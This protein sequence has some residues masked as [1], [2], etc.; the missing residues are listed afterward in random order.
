MMSIQALV[1]PQG[2][3][4]SVGWV[5]I[6]T[7][8]H[9]FDVWGFLSNSLCKYILVGV[10]LL[11]QVN[12]RSIFFAC[13]FTAREE[14]L[15][16]WSLI[17]LE[18]LAMHPSGATT[19]SSR[20][21]RQAPNSRD[22]SSRHCSSV[23]ASHTKRSR[24]TGCVPSQRSPVWFE[25]KS[26]QSCICHF[27]WQ[28]HCWFFFRQTY[29]RLFAGNSHQFNLRICTMWNFFFAC[30]CPSVECKANGVLEKPRNLCAA[31]CEP[32][33]SE[34][35][36]VSCHVHYSVAFRDCCV[37]G[38]VQAQVN[39]GTQLDDFECKVRG[40]LR[41]STAAAHCISGSALERLTLGRYDKD[42]DV[43]I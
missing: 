3:L 30:K 16:S 26:D 19:V 20:R 38:Q 9:G 31:E 1:T 7:A 2:C 10:A 8:F 12:V 17:L 11:S 14:N 35:W 33:W 32:G 34:D 18:T 28:T 6:A 15:E 37:L 36:D 29:D 40:T 22:S 13:F 25:N 24:W 5:L 27:D 21:A 41:N 43:T 39:S 23:I 4:S 42:Y